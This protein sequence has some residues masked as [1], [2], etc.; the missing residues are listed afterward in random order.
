MRVQLRHIV[1]CRFAQETAYTVPCPTVGVFLAGLE[2]FEAP[3]YR[4]PAGATGL[5]FQPQGL[6]IRFRFNER[7]ENYALLFDSEDV[8]MSSQ[9]GRVEIRHEGEWVSVPQFR[10]VD[11]ARLEGWRLEL[12][13]IRSS[14]LSPTARNRLRAEMGVYN[15]LRNLMDEA[16]P[17]VGETVAG[18][19]KRL[20]DTDAVGAR[21][22][23]ELSAACGYS[24]DHLRDLFMREFGMAPKAYRMKRR[25]AEA[26]E[27]IAGNRL[28]VKEI[29][30]RL[31][32]TQTSNFSAAFRSVHGMSPREAI[33]RFRGRG[34]GGA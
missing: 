4:I 26:M 15:L 34:M 2:E 29:A 22:I 23:A 7:R 20:I 1:V 18:R 19:L 33:C 21:S 8:R 17:E 28:S 31:G 6:P 3:R 5:F 12:E 9:P 10:P 24:A 13:R 25:M 11:A 30:A 14:F 32:F 27:D 16:E